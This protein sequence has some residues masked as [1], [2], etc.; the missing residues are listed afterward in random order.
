M[1]KLIALLALAVAASAFT[2]G[3]ATSASARQ[4]Q[5]SRSGSS[6][7]GSILVDGQRPHAVP[8]REG[9]AQ[10][11]LVHRRLRVVL[12]ASADER[13]ARRR[14]RR[15]GVAAR[16]HAPLRRTHAGDVRR[17]IRSTASCRTRRPGRR[18]ARTC[19]TS[20]PAGTCSRPPARRSR[21]RRRMILAISG[22]LRRRL[23]EQR[24]S[25]CRRRRGGT[26]RR[27]RRRRRLGAQAAA[28]RPRPR[29]CAAAHRRGV[30][31]RV[32]AGR[33][34]PARGARV[35]VRDPRRL[36][37]RARLDRRQ[38]LAL[39]QARRRA[40][41]RAPRPRA[42]RPPRARP[43]PRSRRRTCHSLLDPGSRRTRTSSAQPLP[44]SCTAT[45]STAMR[46]PFVSLRTRSGG[47]EARPAP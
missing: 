31:R 16:R 29:G 8:V 40:R 34:R 38:R 45:D 27:R 21:R 46:P 13:Q 17:A 25:P 28:L 12:A 35:R 30:P 26:G 1:K 32:R 4:R 24:R 14:E 2:A 9:Q 18:A 42:A 3:S 43:R 41:R 37:E 36:Q 22:S 33:C 47:A 19:T 23:D 5:G 39:R 44:T 7:L 6:T 11:Q 15:E 20:A 10:P